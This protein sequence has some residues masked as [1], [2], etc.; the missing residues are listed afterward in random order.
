MFLKKYAEFVILF[1]LLLLIAFFVL[2]SDT[3]SKINA[4]SNTVSMLTVDV[5][6]SM[7]WPAFPSPVQMA[8]LPEELQAKLIQFRL[9]L[10][11][12]SGSLTEQ[13]KLHFFAGCDICELTDF[14]D[15]DYDNLDLNRNHPLYETGKELNNRRSELT[16]E[17]EDFEISKLT[18]AKQGLASLLS[19][20]QLYQDFFDTNYLTGIILLS[21]YSSSMYF[22]SSESLDL[23]F[24]RHQVLNISSSSGTDIS[25][26]FKETFKELEKI[27]RREDV[28]IWISASKRIIFVSDG[29]SGTGLDSEAVLKKYGKMADDN[30]IVIDVIGL[31]MLEDEV[32]SKLLSELAELTHGTYAF[33]STSNEIILAVMKAAHLGLGQTI[34]FESS[35]AIL[36]LDSEK[37]LLEFKPTYET[38]VLLASFNWSS[39]DFNMVL[40]DN[41]GN[42]I[43]PLLYTVEKKD[44]VILLNMTQPKIQSYKL[45]SVSVQPLEKPSEYIVLV[46]ENKGPLRIHDLFKDY[47]MFMVLGSVIILVSIHLI[48]T[49]LLKPKSKPTAV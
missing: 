14:N 44:N 24:A 30:G 46:S 18:F 9:D 7:D 11:N 19:L 2:T 48:R 43:D 10:Q 3:I 42:P 15:V 41:A 23:E 29:R 40:E 12:F 39:G 26:G 5:S 25:D 28:N 17:T 32:D 31:G 13:D 33:A 4:P 16:E 45:R 37:V 49:H 27:Q 47:W 38:H 21:G 8:E 20:Q 35:N 1:F 22:S 36:P 34:V 6:G